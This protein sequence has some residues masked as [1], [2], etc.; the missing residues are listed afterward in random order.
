MVG[1]FIFVAWILGYYVD[2]ESENNKK[3]MKHLTY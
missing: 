2:M 3:R 1:I